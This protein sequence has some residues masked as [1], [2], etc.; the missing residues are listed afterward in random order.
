VRSAQ[1]A[2][3]A[4][5]RT[6]ALSTDSY[7]FIVPRLGYYGI[8]PTMPGVEPVK[9]SQC[10]TCGRELPPCLPGAGTG[11][12]CSFCLPQQPRQA[13]AEEIL[14]VEVVRPFSELSRR[15]QLQRFLEE[16]TILFTRQRV[17]WTLQL[18]TL[19]A[20]L[21]VIL[22]CCTATGLAPRVDHLLSGERYAEA[23]ACDGRTVVI[24]D[25]NYR[26]LVLFDVATRTVRAQLE[27]QEGLPYSISFTRDGSKVL[28]LLR[29]GTIGVWDTATGRALSRVSTGI[30]DYGF[31]C[32]SPNG[33][34][35]LTC[36]QVGNT[37][38]WDLTTGR[39]LPIA[40][41]KNA[42]R[43]VF[44]SPRGQPLVVD[45][46]T[47]AGTRFRDI[48]TGVDRC[49]LAGARSSANDSSFSQDDSM[50]VTA[51]PNGSVDIW[52]AHTGSKLTSHRLGQGWQPGPAFSHDGRH[53]L[54]SYYDPEPGLHKPVAE[55]I[56]ERMARQL[57]PGRSG[58]VV[59]DCA[60]GKWLAHLPEVGGPPLL[61]D[62]KTLLTFRADSIQLWDL[63][64]TKVFFF[65]RP[66]IALALALGVTLVCRHVRRD[67][68]PVAARA[69][70][71]SPDS[72]AFG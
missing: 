33:D 40:L 54:L 52:D 62:G 24:P 50:I 25:A 23:Y 55:W 27:G 20:W 45:W 63:P 56:S 58:V 61:P 31:V 13:D 51:G 36:D 10:A 16:P 19:G 60:T 11:Q 47:A 72:A 42:P 67:L 29:D 9:P 44:F 39:P 17:Y 71:S 53:L 46:M 57:F 49:I 69:R 12:A 28:F 8:V 14:D 43:T 35:A 41:T 48:V 7:W 2:L 68:K 70:H 30:R 21:G 4:G 64:P 3:A 37:K 34:R 15:E 38:L 22:A 59:L 6:S 32:A 1:V 26:G 66:S 65:T 5:L 18:L